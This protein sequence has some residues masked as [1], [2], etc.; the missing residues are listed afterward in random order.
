[1]DDMEITAIDENFRKSISRCKNTDDN[2]AAR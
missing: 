1:M 2:R